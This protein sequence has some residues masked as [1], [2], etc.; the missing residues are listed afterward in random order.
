MGQV[1]MLKAI[2]SFHLVLKAAVIRFKC[3]VEI[4][5]NVENVPSVT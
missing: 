3:G 5:G 1:G 4:F 2:L